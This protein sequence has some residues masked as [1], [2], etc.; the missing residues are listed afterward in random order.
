M[1]PC[2]ETGY[3]IDDGAIIDYIA[4]AVHSILYTHFV[5]VFVAICRVSLLIFIK[6]S[7]ET[8]LCRCI[9][10]F[11]MKLHRVG[12]MHR[13]IPFCTTRELSRKFVVYRRISEAFVFFPF[14]FCLFL[15]FFNLHRRMEYL[16]EFCVACFSSVYFGFVR[17]DIPLP[18]RGRRIY[19]KGSR[20]R[21]SDPNHPKSRRPRIKIE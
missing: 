21:E 2:E 18:L 7:P 3:A 5:W 9:S 12:A 19:K 15:F 16:D 14:P 13:L 4:R 1:P 6:R 10:R 20:A 17:K 8:L 11:F